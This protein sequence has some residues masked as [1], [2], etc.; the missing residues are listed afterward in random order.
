MSS[1]SKYSFFDDVDVLTNHGSTCIPSMDQLK[2]ERST[3][4]GFAIAKEFAL[5]HPT[6]VTIRSDGY[7]KACVWMNPDEFDGSIVGIEYHV[8]LVVLLHSSVL[9]YICVS[10]FTHWNAVEG[11]VFEVLATSPSTREI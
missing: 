9:I 5:L 8:I 11:G 10:P 6:G 7:G 4:I 2:G 3:E 1:L